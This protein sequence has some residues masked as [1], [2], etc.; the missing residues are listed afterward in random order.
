MKFLDIFILGEFIINTKKLNM[1]MR[2]RKSN[3]KT[4]YF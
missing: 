1:E 4:T 3:K 2:V